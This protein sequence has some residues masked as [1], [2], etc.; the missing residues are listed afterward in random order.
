[1]N[2]PAQDRTC[3]DYVW[4]AYFFFFLDRIVFHG[5]DKPNG[6][7]FVP[8]THYILQSAQNTLQ[9]LQKTTYAVLDTQQKSF[10]SV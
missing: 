5:T 7:S 4:L 8:T 6:K 3:R 2:I 10:N 1:M 9:K